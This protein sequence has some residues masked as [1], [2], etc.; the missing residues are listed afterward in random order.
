MKTER[1]ILIAFVLNLAFSIFELIGGAFSGSVA[2]ISD[3]I[4]DFGDAA[5][6]GIAYFL[7]RKSKKQPDNKY[8]YGYARY[9]VIGSVVTI[10]ILLIG[11]SFAMYNSVARIVTPVEINYNSMILLAV[12]GACVNF[13]AA[14]FTQEGE[15]LNQKAVNLHLIEDVLGWVTVLIGAVVM[16]FTNFALLDPIMSIAV[17]VFIFVNALKNLKEVLDVLLEKM[18]RNISTEEIKEHILNIDG[19]IDVH[20]VHIWSMDGWNHYA[21]MHVVTNSKPCEIKRLIR[22]ELLDHSIVHV[23]LE[24]EEEGEVCNSRHCHI[25]RNDKPAHHHSHSH[26]H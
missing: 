21:T 13:T 12:I 11:S 20:H 23:T 5:S 19:I 1:N 3:A 16:K 4:H 17:A 2:I 24:I 10:F 7:E 6:I 26:H 18:P 15:S 22:E 9:S 25:E 8:T 14:F